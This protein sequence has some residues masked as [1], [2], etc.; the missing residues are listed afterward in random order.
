MITTII[1]EHDSLK[2]GL[3]REPAALHLPS[4]V[5]FPKK[6]EDTVT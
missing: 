1:K 2:A 5:D 6:K 3:G 4:Q